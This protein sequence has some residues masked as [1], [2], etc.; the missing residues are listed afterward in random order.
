MSSKGI[1]EKN[2]QDCVFHSREYWL[3]EK[4]GGKKQFIKVQL[5]KSYG[6]FIFL[7]EDSQQKIFKTFLL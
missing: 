7:L 5:H 1:N 6:N 4:S 2:L 3:K